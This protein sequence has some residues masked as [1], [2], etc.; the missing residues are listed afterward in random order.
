MNTTIEIYYQPVSSVEVSDD[1]LVAV[2]LSLVNA[3]P[4]GPAGPQGPQGT[5]GPDNVIAGYPVVLNDL[6]QYDVLSFTD[7]SFTNRKQIELT[8]GGNF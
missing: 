1:N 8:D 2:E 5:P 4:I 7:N 3:G 6:T